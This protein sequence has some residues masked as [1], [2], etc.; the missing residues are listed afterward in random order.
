[1]TETKSETGSIVEI[2]SILGTRSI[3]DIE[4]IENNVEIENNVDIETSVE[5]MEDME[6]T[7]ETMED[8][9]TTDDME[10]TEDMEITNHEVP[11]VPDNQLLSN[12]DEPMCRICFTHQSSIDESDDDM[13]L[14]SPCNCTGTSRYICT[15]C[16]DLQIRNGHVRCMSCNMMYMEIS[17]IVTRIDRGD[18]VI[19][20]DSADVSAFIRRFPFSF[21]EDPI[22]QYREYRLKNCKPILMFMIITSMIIMLL[23]VRFTLSSVDESYYGTCTVSNGYMLTAKNESRGL[24]LLEVK[25]VPFNWEFDVNLYYIDKDNRVWNYYNEINE[26]DY[27]TDIEE[28]MLFSNGDIYTIIEN[29]FDCSD[30]FIESQPE[31]KCA[32]VVTDRYTTIIFMNRYNPADTIKIKM[33]FGITVALYSMW[34]M[35]TSA[36]FTFA[37]QTIII[38][39]FM[40]MWI[41]TILIESV[42]VDTLF[43]QMCKWRGLNWV[44]IIGLSFIV[45]IA[46]VD[47]YRSHRKQMRF[48]KEVRRIYR[49]I[50]RR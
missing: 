3:L 1:M 10:T 47:I 18:I 32:Q 26:D 14:I 4:F 46:H 15:E 43:G 27:S 17:N 37:T 16:H 24:G 6:T 11:L 45:I 22:K 31:I 2:G 39:S 29:Q 19:D 8:M 50:N 20:N 9:E 33:Y 30:R 5:T 23:T 28:E 25:A 12:G 41:L 49:I 44:S 48:L 42:F 36:L 34:V 35:G 13:I 7:V 21:T 38:Y 40:K